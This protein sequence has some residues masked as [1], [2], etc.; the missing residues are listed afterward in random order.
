MNVCRFEDSISW[1]KFIDNHTGKSANTQKKEAF[2]FKKRVYFHRQSF[3][4]RFQ[5][6]TLSLHRKIARLIG[7]NILLVSGRIDSKRIQVNVNR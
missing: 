3:G 7:V 1:H 2:I 5:M 4:F 6:I